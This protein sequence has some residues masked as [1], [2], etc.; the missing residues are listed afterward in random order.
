MMCSVV[1]CNTNYNCR[2]YLDIEAM[3]VV[4]VHIVP[5]ILTQ[6]P[7][8]RDEGA[9]DA[10]EHSRETCDNSRLH[11]MHKITTVKLQV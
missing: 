6:G 11:L 9:V 10:A 8:D 1:V 5:L 4:P 7:G 3:P 2:N